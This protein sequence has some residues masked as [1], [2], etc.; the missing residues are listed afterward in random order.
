[1]W[2]KAGH[3]GIEKSPETRKA[4]DSFFVPLCLGGFAAL[5]ASRHFFK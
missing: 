3:D 5:A 1:M 4:R 2:H